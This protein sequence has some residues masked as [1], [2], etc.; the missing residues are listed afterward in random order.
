MAK[1]I[2]CGLKIYKK[3]IRAQISKDQSVCLA[4]IFLS[5]HMKRDKFEIKDTYSKD[6]QQYAQRKIKEGLEYLPIIV[7]KIAEI[8]IKKR[9]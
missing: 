9:K 5:S 2:L 6:I 7:S 8:E 3:N 1:C 4:C